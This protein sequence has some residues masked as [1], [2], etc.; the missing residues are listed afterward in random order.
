MKPKLLIAI[1]I[2]ALAAAAAMLY[3]THE[4]TS[5][6]YDYINARTCVEALKELEADPF[7]ESVAAS[8]TAR[9]PISIQVMV[10]G[11]NGTQLA[12][13]GNYIPITPQAPGGVLPPSNGVAVLGPGA[14]MYVGSGYTVTVKL[15]LWPNALYAGAVGFALLM[16]GFA[17]L[18]IAD[19][20]GGGRQ[21]GEE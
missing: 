13:Y 5:S 14:C 15:G 3:E 6:S 11:V 2:A 19:R 1:G 20:A 21:E 16:G 12:K 8:I 17:S 4:L 7:N 10:E 18:I 9:L